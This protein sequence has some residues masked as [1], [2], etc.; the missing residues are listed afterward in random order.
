M[1]ETI[2][3]TVGAVVALVAV[4][5]FAYKLG[6]AWA[7]SNMP[8]ELPPEDDD[9][10]DEAVGKQATAMLDTAQVL[11][12]RLDLIND[13]EVSVETH[14]P[15]LITYASALANVCKGIAERVDYY[16]TQQDITKSLI[17]A[18]TDRNAQASYIAYLAG[19]LDN[20]RWADL[21]CAKVDNDEYWTDLMINLSRYQGTMEKF[22]AGYIQLSAATLDRLQHLETGFEQLRAIK[23]IAAVS[24]PIADASKRLL[25]VS[26][27]TQLALTG[28]ERVDMEDF[29]RLVG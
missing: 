3:I 16:R 19:R 24:K 18:L 15:T 8:Q 5:G 14:L 25:E 29:R 17:A 2:I 27:A 10:V 11:Q 6:M 1:I 22:E 4:L 13:R 21:A 7:N 12:E 28:P 9:L 20:G 26:N 23:T